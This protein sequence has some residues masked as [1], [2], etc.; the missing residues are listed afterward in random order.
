MAPPL[1]PLSAKSR[2]VPAALAW[3][4][5]TLIALIFL[6]SCERKGARSAAQVGNG[7]EVRPT[8]IDALAFPRRIEPRR[9]LIPGGRTLTVRLLETVSSESA[10]A[11]ERFEAELAAPVVINGRTVLLNHAPV[12]GRVVSVRSSERPTDPGYLRLTLDSVQTPHG[13][14]VAIKTTS[15]WAQGTSNRNR[16]LAFVGGGTGLGALLGALAGDSE[17]AAIDAAPGGAGIARGRTG[18]KDVAFSA[19]RKLSFA[20]VR[21]IPINLH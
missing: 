2:R 17:G 16:N 5:L 18:R 15:I 4:A 19:E 11:G 20:T 8:V 7:Q 14:W 1:S 21:E 10:A 9:V 13:D 12:R 6:P 3:A